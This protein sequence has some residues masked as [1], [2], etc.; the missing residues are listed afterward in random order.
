MK[1]CWPLL[2]RYFIAGL[3]LWLPLMVT[4]WVIKVLVDLFDRSIA[5]IPHQ[6]QPEQLFGFHIPGIGFILT[7][8]IL[9]LTG[10]LITNYLGDR[11][12]IAWEKLLARIPLIRS[13]YSAVKKVSE[14]LLTPSDKSFRKVLLVEY[15]RKGLWCIAFLTSETIKV[16]ALDQDVVSVFIP[17]TPNPTSGFLILVPTEDIIELNISVE[18]ALRMVMSLGVVMPH[19]SHIKERESNVKNHPH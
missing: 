19:F 4:V 3:L 1:K 13:I 2:R 6:Y 5:L 14:A 16:N 8:I 15:P 9:L 10:L 7:V 11:L 17:T 12:L 18:E